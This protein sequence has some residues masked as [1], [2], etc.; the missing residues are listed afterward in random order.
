[1]YL[2]TLSDEEEARLFPHG[3]EDGFALE[4]Y[5]FIDA[6]QNRRPPEVDGWTGLQA[7]AISIAIY[8]S[9][10]SGDVVTIADVLNGKVNGYQQE[11][12]EHWGL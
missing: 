4:I 11:I 12:D 6:I 7:K 3:L 10:Y 9:G 2:D 5:D 8:E 1:M